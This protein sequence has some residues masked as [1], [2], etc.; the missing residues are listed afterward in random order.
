MM[1]THALAVAT[2]SVHS[3][4]D[5]EGF[6]DAEDDGEDDDDG[7]RDKNG[8]TDALL[9]SGRSIILQSLPDVLRSTLKCVSKPGH[10]G[11]D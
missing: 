6:E 3:L 9:P 10:Y 7:E 4:D 8:F 2:G 5:G 1:L 11:S